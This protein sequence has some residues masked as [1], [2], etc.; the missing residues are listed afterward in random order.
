MCICRIFSKGKFGAKRLNTGENENASELQV[1]L[2]TK[3]RE[4]R[5]ACDQVG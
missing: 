1:L 3:I 5:T 4:N 2:T